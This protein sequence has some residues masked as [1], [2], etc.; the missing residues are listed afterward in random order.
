M[1]IQIAGSL[2]G[3]S[4]EVGVA[5]LQ[6]ASQEALLVR[7]TILQIGLHQGLLLSAVDLL[8]VLLVQRQIGAQNFQSHPVERGDGADCVDDVDS[9]A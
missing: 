7:E 8:N 6:F 1:C 2:L 4:L 3:D 9:V 5:Q